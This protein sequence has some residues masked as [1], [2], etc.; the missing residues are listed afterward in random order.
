MPHSQHYYMLDVGNKTPSHRKALAYGCIDVGSAIAKRI[1]TQSIPK[2]CPLQLAEIAGTMASKQTAQ[3][4]P[5]CHPLGLDQSL[6]RCHLD[7]KRHVV[8]VLCMVST[9]GKNRG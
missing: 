8:E 3:L 2:G 6:V 1:Q 7:T 5:L 9:T 4:L